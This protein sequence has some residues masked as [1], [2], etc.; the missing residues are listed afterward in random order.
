LAAEVPPVI[1][2][3]RWD[4]WL[5]LLINQPAGRNALLD[6]F[7]LDV[8]DSAVL[9]GGVFLAA[10][11]WIWFVSGDRREDLRRMIVASA[12]AAL[13]V[14]LIVRVMQTGLPFHPRPLHA[15]AFGL[16]TPLSV[17]PESLKTWSSFPSD[18]AALFFALSVPIWTWSR[19]FGIVAFCW[20]LLVICLPRAYLGF[21][22]PS[23]VLGG[24]V[25][26]IVLMVSLR[27]A[28]LRTSL[29]GRVVRW[30]SS[31]PGTFSA[32]AVLYALE[33]ATLFED[34]RHFALDALKFAS[35]LI[36]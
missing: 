25:L 34:A 8:A 13:F 36:A 21:H 9:K 15:P 3:N 33:L 17:H 4:E 23:D 19:P 16:N 12:L 24:A 26:G 35:K 7:V 18:H 5:V 27:G 29:P 32:I 30:S 2:I 11:C 20:V 10:Y 28:L 22:Y 31:H 1:G 6:Q 14:A